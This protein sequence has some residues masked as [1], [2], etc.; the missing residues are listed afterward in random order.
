MKSDTVTI[1]RR[2]GWYASLGQFV[3]IDQDW[4]A[5]HDD[6]EPPAAKPAPSHLEIWANLL[7]QWAW[8]IIGTMAAVVVGSILV[9]IVTPHGS[10]DSYR[11]VADRSW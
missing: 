5:Y 3:E 1:C 8:V 6:P 4:E 11:L 9:R 7:P 2:C 10:S